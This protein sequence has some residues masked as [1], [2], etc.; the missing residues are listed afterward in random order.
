MVNTIQR[1]K[2]V[3][4]FRAVCQNCESYLE[5]ARHDVFRIFDVFENGKLAEKGYITCPE[6]G[7][8]VEVEL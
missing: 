6:C 5:Y 2:K 1:G 4:L 3:H 8:R 7:R